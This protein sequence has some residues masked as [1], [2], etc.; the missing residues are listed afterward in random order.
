MKRPGIG[1]HLGIEEIRELIQEEA[2]STQWVERMMHVRLCE[3]C[4]QEIRERFPDQGPRLVERLFPALR[5]ASPHV[6]GPTSNSWK[7]WENLRDGDLQAALACELALAQEEEEA[8]LLWQRFRNHDETQ[9]SL[10]IANHPRVQTFGMVRLLLRRAKASWR[11]NPKRAE[12]LTRAALGIF[13][14][15]PWD[16]YHRPHL[17]QTHALAWGYL[18]NALRGQGRLHEADAA[19]S[20]ADALLPPEFSLMEEAWLWRFKSSLRRAQRRFPEAR[21]FARKARNRFAQLRD[22]EASWMVLLE[23]FILK[24]CGDLV[25]AQELLKALLKKEPQD[26]SLPKEIHFLATQYLTINL[27]LQGRGLEARRWLTELET[28]AYEFPEPL[29]QARL[30]W[31]RG[32]V[33]D[34]LAQWRSA[35]QCFRKAREVFVGWKIAYDVALVTLD[36]AAV[37]L[38]QGHTAEA[39]KLASEMLPIFRSLKIERENL[40]TLR[41]LARALRQGEA[42]VAAVREAAWRL[43][44]PGRSGEPRK[45]RAS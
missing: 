2:V 27:A 25:G 36:L 14:H 7:R 1:E 40:A 21:R 28:R 32:L 3:D 15:F 20:R 9:W 16:Q 44:A 24:E 17:E 38:E 39:A 22:P 30:L 41:L 33:F 34:A 42:T 8:A 29:S 23:A 45:P 18:A 4:R 10:L 12:V 5:S 26:S 6:D 43:R 37:E 19:L 11:S 31:T 13:D 35:A